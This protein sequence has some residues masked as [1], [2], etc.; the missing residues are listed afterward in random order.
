MS[1]NP[2]LSTL[3]HIAELETELNRDIGALSQVPYP[4][5]RHNLKIAGEN[6][7]KALYSVQTILNALV[8]RGK[9]IEE[10]VASTGRKLT[11]YEILRKYWGRQINQSYLTAERFRTSFGLESHS[12]IP[13]ELYYLVFDI[14]DEFGFGETF[15]FREGS[16]FMSESSREIIVDVL[17]PLSQ[18]LSEP[19]PG[20]KSGQKGS[21]LSMPPITP[22]HVISYIAGEARNPVLWPVLVHEAFHL[23]DKGLGLFQTMESSLKKPQRLPILDD[24]KDNE[25]NKRWSR[26]IFQDIAAVHYFGPLYSYCLMKYFERLPY[27]QTIEHPEMSSRLYAVSKYLDEIGSRAIYGTDFVSRALGFCRPP[28]QAEIQKYTDNGEL[29]GN[30]RLELDMF[31]ECVT[32]WLKSRN[33]TLFTDR[34]KQYVDESAKA[35]EMTR[36]ASIDQVPFIDAILSFD[37]VVELVF[38]FSVYPV[39]HP[40]LL[41]NVVLA[42]SEEYS[43]QGYYERFVECMK[44]WCIK[45]AWNQAIAS[46]KLPTRK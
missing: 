15:V 29:G 1:T 13:S 14:F 17:D 3:E 46:A 18:P 39:L 2:L 40:T 23:L 45:T 43:R 32:T 34:L 28:I 41:L 9:S 8:E 25:V 33:T 10:L 19:I 12:S 6:Y 24:T 11:L 36:L 42:A 26:E 31:Y 44:K 5:V 37:E 22:A 21:E 20:K 38:K 35:P 7:K 4:K 16:H 30:T 27:I